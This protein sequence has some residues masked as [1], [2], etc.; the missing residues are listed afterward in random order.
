[1]IV[2]RGLLLLTGSLLNRELSSSSCGCAGGEGGGLVLSR[3]RIILF[4]LEKLVN[5]TGG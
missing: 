5:E 3:E 1:M 2:Q 4:V